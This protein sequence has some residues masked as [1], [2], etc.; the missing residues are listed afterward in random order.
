MN[1][2]FL[3]NDGYF[4]GSKIF[5]KFDV[6]NEYVMKISQNSEGNITVGDKVSFNCTA[7]K[8]FASSDIKW[9]MERRN[10]TL[11]YLDGSGKEYLN[12]MN[13]TI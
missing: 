2:S 11:K 9:A 5:D 10:G 4:L 7:S 1:V 3:V 8:F 12:G 13:L 6:K